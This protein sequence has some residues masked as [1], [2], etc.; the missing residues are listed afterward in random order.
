MVDLHVER[1]NMHK[2]QII[3]LAVVLGAALLSGCG[4]RRNTTPCPLIAAQTTS[5]WDDKSLDDAFRFACELGTKTLIVATNGEVVRSMGDLATPHRVH[6][7]RKA[8]L[9]ALVGQHI[10]TEPKQINLESTLGEL[11]I[12]DEPHPLTEQ[13]KEAK[14]LHLIKSVSGINHTA[15]AEGGLMQKDKDRR[16]GQAPNIPGTKWAYNNWDYNALTTIF[17]EETGLSV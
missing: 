13:Q 3:I 17:V 6:S 12:D 15:A 8:L 7:V 5:G 4:P 2:A 10:G 1:G 16:L 9:S 14:V 11:G